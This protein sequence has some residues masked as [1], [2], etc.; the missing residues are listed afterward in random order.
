MA[1]A[2]LMKE[3]MN[4]KYIFLQ[5]WLQWELTNSNKCLYVTIIKIVPK[6]VLKWK[7]IEKLKYMIEKYMSKIMPG[8]HIMCISQN[9]K[10]FLE[11]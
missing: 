2:I 11:E 5:D 8:L 7:L 3:F 6:E 4:I 9:G 1:C 10:M